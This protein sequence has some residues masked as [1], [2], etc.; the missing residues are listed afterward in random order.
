[1][2]LDARELIRHAFSMGPVLDFPQ[3]E[4]A[5]AADLPATEINEVAATI[6]I[7][8]DPVAA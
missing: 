4:H 3:V 1:L 6:V 2:L 5:R 7:N 8:E